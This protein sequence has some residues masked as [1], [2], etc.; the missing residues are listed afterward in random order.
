MMTIKKKIKLNEIDRLTSKHMSNFL[1]TSL[2]SNPQSFSFIDESPVLHFLHSLS[3]SAKYN[4]RTGVEAQLKSAVTN[5]FP[6]ANIAV[7]ERRPISRKKYPVR[8]YSSCILVDLRNSFS[9]SGNILCKALAFSR[10]TS[11]EVFREDTRTQLLLCLEK[12]DCF[13]VEEM[14]NLV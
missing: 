14:T 4:K 12:R 3:L 6:K 8:S 2:I 9:L 13:H 5:P 11:L 10:K 7:A 1:S